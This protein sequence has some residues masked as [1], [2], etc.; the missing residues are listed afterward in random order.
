MTEYGLRGREKKKNHT[1]EGF[2]SNWPHLDTTY[3][4]ATRKDYLGTGHGTV[5]MNWEQQ[6]HYSPILNVSVTAHKFLLSEFTNK[7]NSHSLLSSKW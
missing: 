5:G 4:N 7:Y 2:F 1:Y 3:T 6:N